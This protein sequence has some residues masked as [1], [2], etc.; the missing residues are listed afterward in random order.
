MSKGLDIN[1][2]IRQLIRV[3]HPEDRKHREESIRYLTPITEVSKGRR[4][5][6]YDPKSPIL[7]SMDTPKGSNFSFSDLVTYIDSEELYPFYRKLSKEEFRNRLNKTL[8]D[9][10]NK[11]LEKDRKENVPDS[12]NIWI[13]PNA[14]FV[15]WFHK[16]YLIHKDIVPFNQSNK[17]EEYYSKRGCTKGQLLYI[18]LFKLTKEYIKLHPRTTDGKEMSIRKAVIIVHNENKDKFPNW[19][20]NSLNKFYHLGLDLTINI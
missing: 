14:A 17:D 4:P 9:Y 10:V 5:A 18:K 7:V 2:I 15:N 12:E 13:Q 20:E 19:A 6:Q 3:H 1:K 8:Y 16:K 11:Q